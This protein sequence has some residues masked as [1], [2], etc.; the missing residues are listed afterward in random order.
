VGQHIL[1]KKSQFGR[2]TWRET[3]TS[4]H[5]FEGE[6]TPYKLRQSLS[7][8]EMIF[9]VWQGNIALTCIVTCQVATEDVSS[10]F[11]ARFLGLSLF[12][13]RREACKKLASYHEHRRP[14][15]IKFRYIES[16]SVQNRSKDDDGKADDEGY[17]GGRIGHFDM[18]TLSEAFSRCHER[19]GKC[20]TIRQS[21]RGYGVMH[22]GGQ[23]SRITRHNTAAVQLQARR[24]SHCHH[25][26]Q[27][28][29]GSLQPS[30]LLVQS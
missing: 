30:R 2:A 1:K 29:D 21:W 9:R 13:P 16:S 20:T 22:C 18:N 12:V 3:H 8:C 24:Y 17:H 27:G 10:P 26:H 6:G 5:I 23:G 4:T 14:H 11:S 7:S 15:M 19:N 25:R 28:I